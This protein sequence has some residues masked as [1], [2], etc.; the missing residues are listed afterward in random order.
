MP[1]V[2]LRI[3]TN[4]R[5]VEHIR[6]TSILFGGFWVFSCFAIQKIIHSPFGKCLL[7]FG[8]IRYFLSLSLNSL[9]QNINLEIPRFIFWYK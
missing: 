8:L 9:K 2:D 1:T 6:H 4:I 5:H 3:I 7:L